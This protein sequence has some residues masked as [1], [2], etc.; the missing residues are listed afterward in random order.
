MY[1]SRLILNARSREARRD[2]G[3]CQALHRTLLSAFP[4]AEANSEGAREQFELLY[5]ADYDRRMK[6]FAVLVQSRVAPD[7]SRLPDGYVLPAAGGAAG[8]ECKP[9][10]DKLDNLGEGVRLRFR[11]R[12]NPTRR[13]WAGNK[14]EESGAQGKRVE[15]RGEEKQLDWLRRKG[16]AHGFRLVSVQLPADEEATQRVVANVRVLPEAKSHGW[17]RDPMA[18]DG[19]GRRKKSRLTFGA[20][21]F[22]GELEVTDAAAFRR[23]VEEGVGPAKAYGFGLLSLARAAGA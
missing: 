15:L 21:L 5:R 14:R 19:D 7:W 22:E 8:C 10:A 13:V 20:A 6:S 1:L 16:E 3:D 18:D 17:R 11:L 9:I 12:A 2:L 23:A 4:Q